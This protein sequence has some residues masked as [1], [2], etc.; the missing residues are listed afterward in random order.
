LT[1]SLAGAAIP[2][3]SRLLQGTGSQI[4]GVAGSGFTLLGLHVTQD[5][6]KKTERIVMD[7]GDMNGE[8]QRGLPGYFHVEMRDNPARVII[9]LAQTPHSKVDAQKLAAAFQKSTMVR[10]TSITVDPVDS[11]LT[12]ALDVKKNTKARVMQV[13]GQKQTSKVVVDLISE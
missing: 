9:D 2:P 7:V 13:A 5:H 3:K 1:A 11:T 4:G 10:K 12:I 8:P 6:N